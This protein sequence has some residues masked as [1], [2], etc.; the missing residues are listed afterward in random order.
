MCVCV[1]VLYTHT[2]N[3]YTTKERHQIL[4][5]AH[6]IKQIITVKTFLQD[7]V[8]H[9]LVN[10][11]ITGKLGTLSTSL[12]TVPST[13]QHCTSVGKIQVPRAPSISA[14]IIK[15]ESTQVLSV[16]LIPLVICFFFTIH[17]K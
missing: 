2:H 14:C 6:A 9:D 11:V 16:F 5:L 12:H 3:N 7:G 8:F 15:I 4:L 1:C 13:M 10:G 17:L